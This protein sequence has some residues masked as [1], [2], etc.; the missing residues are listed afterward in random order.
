MVEQLSSRRSANGDS[1]ST[2]ND[3]HS[4]SERHSPRILAGNS[5]PVST[6]TGDQSGFSQTIPLWEKSAL[7]C[8][9]DSL[10][11]IKSP[12][13]SHSTLNSGFEAARKRQ[14]IAD[15][16]TSQGPEHSRENV[17]EPA[18]YRDKRTRVSS[19]LGARI[20]SGKYTRPLGYLSVQS[21]GLS[22]FV[23]DNFWG[24]VKGHVS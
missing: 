6:Q 24:L 16:H 20:S 12:L 10:Q 4:G 2:L 23:G 15:I 7:S 8:S 17:Q 13:N 21:G 5:I 14:R 9:E 19:H 3:Q 1:L 22:R 11:N 18:P